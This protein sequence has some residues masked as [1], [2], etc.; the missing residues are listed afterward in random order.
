MWCFAE[1][2]KILR[3]RGSLVMQE[4][5]NPNRAK[6]SS[7]S[8]VYESQSVFCES[9]MGSFIWKE[10]SSWTMIERWSAMRVM[11]VRHSESRGMWEELLG[12]RDRCGPARG[13]AGRRIEEGC[14]SL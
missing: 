10:L 2:F 9:A 8:R 11:R 13:D 6:D 3:K 4:E 14:R 5:G 1:V 7:A 12:G